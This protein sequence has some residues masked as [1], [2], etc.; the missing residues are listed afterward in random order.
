MR[1]G[2]TVISNLDR[3]I[4]LFVG[5]SVFGLVVSMWF[6][7]VVLWYLRRL[8]E[9]NK[10][11]QRLGSGDGLES[12]DSRVLR[13]WHEGG[14]AT[15]IVPG[16]PRRMSFLARLDHI[17]RAL[18]LK[19]PLR[20][21]ILGVIGVTLLGFVVTLGLTDN[22]VIALGG[23]SSI[24][25]ILWVYA[26]RQV[27]RESELF[28]TQ[29]AD[30]LGLAARS[31]RAGHP[32]L[33]AFQ[34]IVEEMNP[35]VST[36]FAEVCQQQALGRSLEEAIRTTAAKS[37]SPDMKLFAASIVIQLRGGGNLADMMERL[38][39]VIRDR[40]RLHRR[41]RILTSQTQLSKRILIALPFAL[42]VLIHWINPNYVLP[43]L[44]TT[45]GRLLL[46]LGVVSLAA[47][48]WIMNRITEL[49]Y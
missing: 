37:T 20:T 46:I 15:T 32:L 21:M 34:L 13:L 29:I 23:A 19:V 27:K 31:L 12:K 42:F 38:A 5:I 2:A 16:I 10:L 45:I 3:T 26:E 33:G 9:R 8:S 44:T 48:T 11:E 6:I 25:I 35:P 22:M 17:H 36:V 24:V 18:E 30:A 4:I 39:D 14:V 1:R 41:A 47:G 49:R 28:E 43:L 7:G 40:I